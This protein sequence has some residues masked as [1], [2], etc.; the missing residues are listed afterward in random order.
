[1]DTRELRNCFGRFAT[2]VTVVTCRTDTGNH[3]ITVNSFTSVSLDPPLVLVSIDNRAR[4]RT[5][6]EGQPFT[7]NILTADQKDLALHFAGRPQENLTVPWEE[8]NLGPRLGGVLAWIECSPWQAYAGGDHVLYLGKVEDFWY[9][10]EDAL[11]FYCGRFHS[12][13]VLGGTR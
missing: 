9:G 5:Y 4:A 12:L 2:G 13:P 8:G 6:L 3:G 7:V 10:S 1:M 11:L